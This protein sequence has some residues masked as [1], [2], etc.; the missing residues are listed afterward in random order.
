[1]AGTE[2][3]TF[4]VLIFEFFKKLKKKFYIFAAYNGRGRPL[5][6]ASRAVGVRDRDRRRSSIAHGC[7]CVVEERS[8]RAVVQT[9]LEPGKMKNVGYM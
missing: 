6:A 1:M 3:A 9:N 5:M 4:E 2:Q 7:C 8:R